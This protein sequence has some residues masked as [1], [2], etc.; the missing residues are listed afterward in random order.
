MMRRFLLLT[1]LLPLF[2]A[3]F[4]VG[5]RAAR[6]VDPC[7]F[8]VPSFAFG[9]NVDLIT[10][11]TASQSYNQTAQ[12]ITITCNNIPNISPTQAQSA[13]V[14]ISIPSDATDAR[15]M[16]WTAPLLPPRSPSSATNG[17][18]YFDIYKDP[19]RRELW[20]T[21]LLD[22]PTKDLVNGQT[23]TINFYGQL[24]P[25]QGTA[26]VGSYSGSFPVKFRVYLYPVGGTI[27]LCAG[28]GYGGT[29]TKPVDVTATI[30]KMCK[31]TSPPADMVFQSQTIIKS[32]DDIRAETAIRLTCTMDAPYWI[33]LDNGLNAR[34]GLCPSA[35]QRCMISG[36]NRINYE[37][38]TD[39]G[40]SSRW[41]AK[42]SL[43]T[44]SGAG[45]GGNKDHGVYGKIL[46]GNT[47]PPPG[48]YSDTIT[49]TVN[50]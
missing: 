44:V 18:L 4:G 43:D 9:Q 11:P 33:S 25:Y 45:I 49:V 8:S 17:K 14:C 48:K 5:A 12:T 21:A 20:P 6:A 34:N 29:I 1:L 35:S 37:L 19:G 28:E 3:G 40:R 42:Q 15:V 50:F 23:A 2:C 22:V 46:P 10:D 16:N 32:T 24:S 31:F 47:S 36:S 30:K 39:A 13:H 7:T 38:F 41:G 27:P 26:S